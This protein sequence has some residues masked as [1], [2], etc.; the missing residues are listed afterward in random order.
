MSIP[1]P[2]NVGPWYLRN[3][4][5][6]LALDEGTGSVYLRTGGTGTSSSVTL[7][8]TSYSSFGEP[9]SVP[10]YPVIQLDALYGFDPKEFETYTFGTGNVTQNTNKTLFVTN[11]GTGAYGY[12]VIRS[13]RII[14]YRPGQGVMARFTAQFDSPQAGTTLRAGLFAQE[15]ALNIGYNGEQV[16]ILRQNGGKAEIVQFTISASTAGTGVITLNGVSTNVTITTT[17][18]T[19]SAKEIAATSFTG[20]TAEQVDNTVR[21][22][23]NSV[24]VLTPGTYSVGGTLTGTTSVLQA[25]AANNNNWT[26]QQDWNIDTL[27]GN[28]PSGVDID[29][30]KLNVYQIQF[31]WLGAGEIRYSIENPITGDMI[32][33]H[34]E[35][36]SN[37]N[38]DVH[39]DNPSFKMGYIAANLTGD[40][41][42]TNASTSGASMMAA[43]EGLEV[44]GAFPS[45][46]TSTITTTL[47]ANSNY[48]VLSLKNE[49][50]FQ[51]KI[52]LRK[53]KMKN[54]SVAVNCTSPVIVHLYLNATKSTGY[55]W[56]SLSNFNCIS[57]DKDQGTISNTVALAEYVINADGS[58]V[59]DLDKLELTI[60]PG[61]IL[62]I[63]VTS[64]GS[65]QKV[66]A[67]ATW[68]E[69]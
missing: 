67:A 42:A 30:S 43:R 38:N 61:D 6:A 11:T 47:N 64:T 50:I 59:F 12:G 35:H 22:L 58:G 45:S 23:S 20:W 15:Q 14:R 44:E 65:I 40:T 16:G 8:S 57:T 49:L 29:F 39:L 33:F 26:Y 60:P 32:Y 37:R 56:S 68:I 25:G 18:T 5:Q 52:N 3:I 1:D 36:Y 19:T 21:F 4:T 48:N 28:G 17:N 41:L 66:D 53:V 69:V 13:T 46:T 51:N 24:G 2:Q 9:I 62:T 10:L 55:T 34:H 7:E 63:S 31:R 54:M 27:D